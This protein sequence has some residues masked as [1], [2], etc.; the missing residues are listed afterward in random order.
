[1]KPIDAA[2]SVIGLPVFGSVIVFS[3]PE[4][5]LESPWFELIFDAIGLGWV[6]GGVVVV[7]PDVVVVVPVVDD[8]VD[9]AF[10]ECGFGAFCEGVV[11]FAVVVVVVVCGFPWGCCT[12]FAGGLAAATDA[13]VTSPRVDIT[14]RMQGPPGRGKAREMPCNSSDI[15][16]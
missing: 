16:S 4:T 12:G 9:G 7:P 6:V 10:D 3:I 13:A 14:M 15:P 11:G 2:S 8:V 5:L 1:L